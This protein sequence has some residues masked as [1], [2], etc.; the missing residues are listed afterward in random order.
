MQETKLELKVRIKVRVASKQNAVLS[1]WK[2]SVHSSLHRKLTPPWYYTPADKKNSLCT[3][4]LYV[5]LQTGLSNKGRQTTEK[6]KARVSVSE[7]E[8]PFILKGKKKKENLHT[9]NAMHSEKLYSYYQQSTYCGSTISSQGKC[10]FQRNR[11][12]AIDQLT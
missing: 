9:E 10:P 1:L 2:N 8:L 5:L 11:S 3:H 7:V 4:Q 12:A 6:E